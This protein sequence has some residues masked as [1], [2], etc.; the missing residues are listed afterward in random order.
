MKVSR[1]RYLLINP[2]ALIFVLSW[3]SGRM[4]LLSPV[5]DL[6]IMFNLSYR[7]HDIEY[8]VKVSLM[9]SEWNLDGGSRG[10]FEYAVPTFGRRY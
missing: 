5:Y 9:F 4:S 8:D 6:I 1:R 2:K 7:L 3:R 10:M